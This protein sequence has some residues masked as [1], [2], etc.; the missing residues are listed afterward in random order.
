MVG[1]RS[2]SLTSCFT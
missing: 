1:Y 2:D